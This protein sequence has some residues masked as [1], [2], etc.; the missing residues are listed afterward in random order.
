MAESISLTKFKTLDHLRFIRQFRRKANSDRRKIYAFDI[1]ATSNG[2]ML[3]LANNNGDRIDLNEIS[4]EN[5]LKFL[6]CKRYQTSWCFF[7]NLHYDARIIL[8][9]ILLQSKENEILKFYRTDRIKFLDF[10]IWYME[11]KVL[12]IRKGHHSVNF[13]DIQQYFGM[14]K[15]LADAYQENISQLPKEY[16]QMKELRQYFSHKFYNRNKNKVRQYCIQDC[17]YIKQLSEFWVDLFKDAFSFYPARWISSGYLAEKVLINNGTYIPKFDQSPRQVQELA[18]NS[19]IG[20]RTELIVRGHVDYACIY[21]I[22][23]AYTYALTKIPDFT[24]GNNWIQSNKIETNSHLGFFKIRCNIPSK[25][26]SP[27]PFTVKKKVVFP[28]WGI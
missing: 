21:D 14:G 1:E 5:V 9:M 15:S 4:P 17:K 19:Y 28:I 7:W 2:D 26:L 23:S 18:W 27:F 13:F 24:N 3:L 10:N 20:S 8:R 25:N 12:A 6:F 16:L 11:K 22:N